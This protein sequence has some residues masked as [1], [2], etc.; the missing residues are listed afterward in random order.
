MTNQRHPLS[1]YADWVAGEAIRKSPGVCV[2]TWIEHWGRVFGGMVSVSSMYELVALIGA[3]IEFLGGL[4]RGTEGD[5]GCEDFIAY[6]ND[7]LVHVQPRYGALH[8][9]TDRS[10]G[11]GSDFFTMFR[12]RSLHGMT[13]AATAFA[14][15]SEVIAWWVGYAPDVP[16]TEHLLVDSHGRLQVDL[17][18]L[19]E[20][21]LASMQRF[22]S[23]LK[24]NSQSVRG[25]QRALW[26]RYLPRHLPRSMWEAAGV[27][28]GLPI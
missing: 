11:N 21:L 6:C 24:A 7:F 13:P 28:L 26:F 16:E 25:F 27:A 10:S 3:R 15:N 19:R 20:E 8:C 23:H 4:H 12:N 14:N 17:E 18:R 5:T 22:V 2:E 9:L 1:T